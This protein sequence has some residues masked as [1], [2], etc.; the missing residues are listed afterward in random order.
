MNETSKAPPPLTP[1]GDSTVKTL[2]SDTEFNSNLRFSDNRNDSMTLGSHKV[3]IRR[4]LQE[5][6]VS[7][8]SLVDRA[9]YGNL[10][11]WTFTGSTPFAYV[12]SEQ[13]PSELDQKAVIKPPLKID[14]GVRDLPIKVRQSD[15]RQAVELGRPHIVLHDTYRLSP[16][17]CVFFDV[18][19]VAR[20]LREKMFFRYFEDLWILE[21]AFL[22]LMADRRIDLKE[23]KIMS[24]TM[25]SLTKF[26]KKYDFDHQKIESLI[27]NETIRVLVSGNPQGYTVNDDGP[28]LYFYVSASEFRRAYSRAPFALNLDDNEHETSFGFHAPDNVREISEAGVT[29]EVLKPLETSPSSLHSVEKV[30]NCT[31]AKKKDS[32]RSEPSKAHLDIAIQ[33]LRSDKSSKFYNAKGKVKRAD[34]ARYLHRDSN[35]VK[36]PELDRFSVTERTIKDDYIPEWERN[37]QL[38]PPPNLP[39]KNQKVRLTV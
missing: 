16:K 3:Q 28:P 23:R 8:I 11:F 20:M 6:G 15:L 31:Q 35:R 21:S 33:V 32:E 2:H 19:V 4:A 27:K 1:L 39:S 5:L 12:K 26:I 13:I 7:A 37:S 34:L 24:P 38:P 14:H 10:D 22:Q 29:I 17:W 9:M 30:M 25:I 36:W 18:T